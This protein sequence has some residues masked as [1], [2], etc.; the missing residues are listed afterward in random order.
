MGECNLNAVG[1]SNLR[2]CK[3]LI[4]DAR[5]EY[6][7]QYST[8]EFPTDTR[9]LTLSVG[10]SILPASIYDCSLKLVPGSAPA[11]TATAA[12]P[13]AQV[14]PALPPVTSPSAQQIWAW[15]KY[16]ALLSHYPFNLSTSMAEVCV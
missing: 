12:Q 14:G 16:F 1:K 4:E 8:S 6:D 2:A 15:R 5:L 9:V 13:A 3:R 10:R 11:V 7:F